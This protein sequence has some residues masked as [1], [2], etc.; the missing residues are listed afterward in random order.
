MFGQ[1][2]EFEPQSGHFFLHFF[3]D[4][5]IFY[6]AVYVC[7]HLSFFSPHFE[8][9]TCGIFAK[10]S[11]AAPLKGFVCHE[12]GATLPT[13]SIFRNSS[14]AWNCSKKAKIEYSSHSH[15]C[16]MLEEGEAG[17]KTSR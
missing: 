11:R 7:V 15:K 9:Q 3:T 17:I 16:K 6:L 5:L 13:Q 4:D 10:R 8:I 1:G 12:A 14:L 2:P